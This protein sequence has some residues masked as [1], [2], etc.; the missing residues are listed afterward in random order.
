M[1]K[2]EC[3]LGIGVIM[4]GNVFFGRVNFSYIAYWLLIVVFFLFGMLVVF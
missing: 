4:L 3:W 2:V 1:K